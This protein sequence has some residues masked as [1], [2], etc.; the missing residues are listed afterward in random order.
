MISGLRVGWRG[1]ELQWVG[2]KGGLTEEGKGNTEYQ[3]SFRH[4]PSEGRGGNL[5][6]VAQTQRLLASLGVAVDRLTG[7][8]QGKS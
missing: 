6:A 4:N 2:G 7:K 1:K 5:V 8:V 3:T